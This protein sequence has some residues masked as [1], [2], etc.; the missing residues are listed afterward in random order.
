MGKKVKI[1][2]FKPSR[3]D[4]TERIFGVSMESI[5]YPK[6]YSYVK[7]LPDVL[8]QGENPICVPC[9]ISSYLNWKENLK[10][11]S[12]K[13]NK[14]NYF[15]IYKIKT[16]EGEGMTFKEALSYLRHH[17][18]SSQSGLLKIKGYA[19]VRSLFS[20]R[21]AI[22]MNG[23]CL[24]A[25][26]VY[27]YSNEFWKRRQGDM[28]LGYHAISIVGYD[29]NGFIIRNSWGSSFANNG[30]TKISFEDANALIEI[31]TI[32]E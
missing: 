16:T 5:A 8:N 6:Q 18:V 13:D 24:G 31:W 10:D 26:P 19:L 29:K 30:Y 25:L 28:L 15:E 11:G 4:G 12:R 20:L 23:P 27:N 1:S 2:G 3:I 14:V 32:L 21:A 9:S 22:L 7:Y 17:G